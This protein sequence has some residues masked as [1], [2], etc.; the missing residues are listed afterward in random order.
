MSL[1]RVLVTGGAGALGSDLRELLS[2]AEVHAPAR[3][4]LDV[5]DDDAVAAAF[6]AHRPE[7]VFNCA[8]YHNVDACEREEGRALAVN[9]VA[10][11]RL[12]ERCASGGAKLVHLSTYYVFDGGREEPYDEDDLP[13]PLSAYG[14]S[15]LAGEQLALAYAPSALVVRTAG[16]YGLHGSAA[17]GG[18]FVQRILGR[19]REQGEVTMVADQRLSPTFTADLA[20]ALVA[21]V[22]AGAEGLLHLTNSGVCSWL[23]FTQAIFEHAG[24]EA[25]I[26][27]VETLPHPGVAA[28]PLNGALAAR[29]ARALGLQPMRDWR[30]ALAD[31]MGR[32]GLAA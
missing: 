18:N 7:V 25:A 27:P 22:E 12:A 30:E 14:V 19:A 26:E 32:A 20:R 9:A 15:K 24:V 6:D 21:A 31:Y 29:R 8:A 10:V 1:S 5:T 4:E 23:E 16:L 11:K 2:A 17:K 3:E 13:M 28:R